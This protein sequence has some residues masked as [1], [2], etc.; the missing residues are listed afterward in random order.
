MYQL[1]T[2]SL[3]ILNNKYEWFV[4]SGNLEK[5]IFWRNRPKIVQKF[6]EK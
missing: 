1:E 2:T 6:N 3:R 5:N 4:V